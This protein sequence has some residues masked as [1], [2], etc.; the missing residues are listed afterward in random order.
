MEI[1]EAFWRELLHVV[2]IASV[3]VVAYYGRKVLKIGF[4]RLRD[5]NEIEK[6]DHYLN[7]LEE[8]VV[9]AVE[10]VNQTYVDELK[11]HDKFNKE[12]QAEAFG[13]AK[14]KVLDRLSDAGIEILEHS[15]GDVHEIV[16]AKIEK[17]VRALKKK[18]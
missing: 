10:E 6:I 14:A 13:K 11:E 18:D 16:D 3:G 9:D 4:E 12:A 5:V 1:L 17:W 7:I 8:A 2:I 15:Q